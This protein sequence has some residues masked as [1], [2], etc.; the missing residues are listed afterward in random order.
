MVDDAGEL[1]IRFSA[2]LA[3]SMDFLYWWRRSQQALRF[4]RAFKWLFINVIRRMG[5]VSGAFGVG[6]EGGFNG[7]FNRGGGADMVRVAVGQND[8]LYVKPQF[9]NNT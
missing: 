1:P 7:G 6:G 4:G 5:K 3:S 2:K 9:I 8:K